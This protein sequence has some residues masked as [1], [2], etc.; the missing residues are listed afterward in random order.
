MENIQCCQPANDCRHNG[1][2]QNSER[3][4]VTL[5]KNSQNHI[6]DEDCREKQQG[7]RLKQ[8]SEYKRL[9]LKRSLHGWV[10]RLDL[11][12]GILD[13]LRSIA[14]RRIRQQVKIKRDT[15]KLV[16]M[17]NGLRPNNLLA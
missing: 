9:A 10:M 6:H 12:Y 13:V 17:V 4:H 5:V 14:N 16:E 2:E 1:R 15:G 7:Q 3:V 8:L 11:R